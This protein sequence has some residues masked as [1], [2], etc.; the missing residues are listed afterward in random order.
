MRPTLI[1]ALA[2]ASLSPATLVAQ[3]GPLESVRWLTACWEAASPTRR[4]V[5]RWQTSGAELK[6]DSRTIVA[7]TGR[8]SEGER[9]RIYAIADTLVYDAHPSGQART[10]FKVVG[11]RGDSVV[12]ANPAHDFPQRIVYKKVGA[13]SLIARI[14]GDRAGR[15][16]PTTFSYRR[17][18]C[19]TVSDNPSDAIEATLR[20]NYAELGTMLDA[21][22]LGMNSWFVKHGGPDITYVYWSTAGYRPPVVTREGI[23]RVAAQPPST[24][25]SPF[26]DRKNTATV[27][28]ALVRGDTAEVLATLI[29]SHKFVDGTGRYGPANEQRLRRIEQRRLD[30]WIKRDGKWTLVNAAFVGDEMTIDGKAVSRN[31]RTLDE[32][33]P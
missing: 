14:E 24:T 22:T 8:E 10:E 23:D 2:A 15:R 12:F 28:R 18:N 33:A 16:Q 13:D 31:G 3:G 21:S 9:L 1:L 20:A 30:R 7:A 19:G 32:K 17:I 6:G 25:P 11:A 26:T 29:M 5:E 4:I 27:D